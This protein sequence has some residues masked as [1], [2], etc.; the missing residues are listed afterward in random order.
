MS[1]KINFEKYSNNIVLPYEIINTDLEKVDSDFLK[2]VL[3]IFQDTSKLFEIEEIS[4][5]LNIS[6]KKVRQAFE[7]WN[8]R[9]IL[10]YDKDVSQKT[11][12]ADK[13]KAKSSD[14]DILKPSKQKA[15]KL[16]NNVQVEEKAVNDE[17]AFVLNV[18][19]EMFNITISKPYFEV[20]DY[21][22]T[23]LKIPSDVV[24]LAYHYCNETVDKFNIKYLQTFCDSWAQMGITTTEKA[25]KYL[26]E[27]KKCSP[28]E[29]QIK[30]LF[31]IDKTLTLREK[32]FI[33]VWTKDY[34]YDIDM[35]SCAGELTLSK[36][37]QYA[38]PYMNTVLSNWYAKC[39]L[40]ASQVQHLLPKNKQNSIN[41][42]VSTNN[43]PSN[44][45]YDLKEVE[46]MW[47]EVV[48]RLI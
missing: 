41:N 20:I 42:N 40:N 17:V 47:K 10:Q 18:I 7:Y 19:T 11:N 48:P 28:E 34:Q 4:D 13:S 45:S 35:I 36:T 16:Q 8:N 3:V 25:D 9:E 29:E 31:N 44:T 1:Y 38:L 21:I 23:Q 24:L 2:V 22:I 15:V 30:S 12:V 27:L 37:G 43:A 39:Y 6:H 33:R 26:L 46:N 32:D 14:V 5:I